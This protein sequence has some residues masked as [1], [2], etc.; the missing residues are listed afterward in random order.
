MSH[1]GIRKLLENTAKSL[2]DDIQ[3]TYARD[4]DFNLLRDKRYPFISTSPLIATPA[5][6]VNGVQ[7]YMKSWA[8]QM[9]FYELDRAESTGEEYAEILDTM[10]SYVDSFINKINFY[11][12]ETTITSNDILI[13]GIRQEPFIKAMADILTG[14]IL[15][16]TITV[17][18]NFDY[19][20]DNGC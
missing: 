12:T 8:V 15:T 18:D 5:Y 16:F 10:D 7:N 14:Y 1:K 2:G 19:C 6:T 13:T 9:A 4:S 11:S 3:Y 17:N 20:I